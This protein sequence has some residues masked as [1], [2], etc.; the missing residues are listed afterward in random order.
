MKPV[1]EPKVKHILLPQ[2]IVLEDTVEPVVQ[3]QVGACL[4]EH[5]QVVRM[6]LT[7]NFQW[8]SY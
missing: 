1:M 5:L 3:V 8:V 6:L 7:P 2:T 4:M